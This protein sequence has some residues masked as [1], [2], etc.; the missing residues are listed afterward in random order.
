MLALGGAV[1]GSALI[2][3]L[4]QSYTNKANI[5]MNEARFAEQTELANTTLSLKRAVGDCWAT[6]KASRLGRPKACSK[7]NG[8]CQYLSQLD[9][10]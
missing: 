2:N 1:I 5:A 9:W 3:A 6:F 7:F 8:H 4:M 10:R